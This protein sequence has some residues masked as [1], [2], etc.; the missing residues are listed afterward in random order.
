V[1][2][3]DGHI[4]TV[5]ADGVALAAIQALYQRSQR[6][7]VE[8]ATLQQQ[9]TTLQQQNADLAGR[10]ATMEGRL[11]ALEPPATSLAPSRDSGILGLLLSGL[12]LGL[13][14][15]GRNGILRLPP[16]GER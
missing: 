6:L 10:L 2:E 3:D 12:L 13:V 4:S 8:T 5:D 11:A 9:V 15:I 7:E 14:V 16:G 1:G